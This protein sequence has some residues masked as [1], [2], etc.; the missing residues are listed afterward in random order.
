MLT[1]RSR[2]SAWTTEADLTTGVGCSGGVL[3]S[4]IGGMMMVLTLTIGALERVIR[5][6]VCG[7]TIWMV[8]EA[9]WAC[10]MK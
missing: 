6:Y 5:L 9:C 7:I 4:T 8:L 2:K 3:E 10:Q 1:A